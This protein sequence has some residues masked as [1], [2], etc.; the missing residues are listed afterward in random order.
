MN[1]RKEY[2]TDL[3]EVEWAILEQFLLKCGLKTDSDGPGRP[4]KHELREIINAIRYVLRNGNSW[5]NLPG[6]FPPWQSIYYHFAKWRDMGLWRKLNKYLRRSLRK[7]LR[8]HEEP[9]AG[10]VDSPHSD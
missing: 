4:L 2:T 7:Q 6:D 8:R 3:S 9:S 1:R 10:V 5:R